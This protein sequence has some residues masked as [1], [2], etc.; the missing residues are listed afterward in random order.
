[1][2]QDEVREIDSV[3]ID[4]AYLGKDGAILPGQAAVIS[5]IELV[6]CI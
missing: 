1:M 3:R 4:G 5:L 6:S 2:L